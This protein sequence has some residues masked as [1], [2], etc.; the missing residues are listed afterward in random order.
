[1]KVISRDELMDMPSGTIYQKWKP[2]VF[3]EIY[4]KRETIVHDGKNIDWF[5]SA[6]SLV[7]A[8]CADENGIIE[9]EECE[10]RDGC[11]DHDQLYA[12]WSASDSDVFADMLWRNK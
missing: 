10:F 9:M 8:G 5:H 11:F 7:G 4:V 1:M 3:G 2:C 6:Y 12:I